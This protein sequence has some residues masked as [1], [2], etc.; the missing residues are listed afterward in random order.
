MLHT[1]SRISGTLK[2]LPDSR[3]SFTFQFFFLSLKARGHG[4]RF[5]PNLLHKEGRNIP[6][7][8]R[9]SFFLDNHHPSA[10]DISNPCMFFFSSLFASSATV[11]PGD[12]LDINHKVRLLPN[13]MHDKICGWEYWFCFVLGRKSPGSARD[14]E[15]FSGTC[16]KA[17]CLFQEGLLIS[18]LI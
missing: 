13:C 1:R 4:Q 14:C 18:Q 6:S 12:H 11:G 7:G 15:K 5:L 2:A 16:V 9:F 8:R 3:P 10:L 17:T